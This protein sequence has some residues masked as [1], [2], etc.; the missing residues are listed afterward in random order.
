MHNWKEIVS[1]IIN[2]RHK[3]FEDRYQ[4]SEWGK[5]N[6][7]EHERL[8]NE[9]NDEY[10]LIKRGDAYKVIFIEGAI[11]PEGTLTCDIQPVDPDT[12]DHLEN[13]DDEGV[14]YN[15]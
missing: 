15:L 10:I 3:L 5:T 9:L 8:L 11:P 13:I 6:D 7:A 2:R 14:P 12:E 4:H 1:R